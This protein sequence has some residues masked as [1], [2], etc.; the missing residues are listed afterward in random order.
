MK[1]LLLDNYDSFTFNL[2]HYLQQLTEE[3]EVRRNNEIS[4]QEALGFSHLVISP[5]PGLPESA[6]ITNQL[7]QAAVGSH[8][9]LGVCLGCQ[10]LGQYF[11]AQLFNQQEVAHGIQRAVNQSQQESWLLAGL[12][13]SFRVGLYHSWAIR[14]E[15]LSNKIRVTARSERGVAMAMEHLELPV[16]GVQFHPESIMTDHGLQILR[17]WLQR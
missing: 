13:Q 12:P 10:A 6:G 3:V 15:G 2:F 7:I 16:A 1:V 14:E 8:A 5:G 4:V 17:N 9:I 11:G